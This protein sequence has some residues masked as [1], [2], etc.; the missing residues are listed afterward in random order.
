MCAD[1]CADGG[2]G[3]V[4]FGKVRCQVEA[5]TTGGN[6]RDFARLP[7]QNLTFSANGVCRVWSPFGGYSDAK[8]DADSE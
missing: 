3:R 1:A 5:A 6:H 7:R 4:G 2:G 8:S